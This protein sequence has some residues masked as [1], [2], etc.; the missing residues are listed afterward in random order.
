[1]LPLIAPG[2]RAFTA[3]V[4]RD[5]SAAWG[6]TN[7]GHTQ[8]ISCKPEKI[9]CQL[10]TL[11]VI[12]IGIG[13]GLTASPLPHHRT[14]GSR[15][16][17]FGRLS[18][19]YTAPPPA[20][21]LPACQPRVHPSGRASPD[22]APDAL[23]PLHPGPRLRSTVGRSRRAGGPM[24]AAA[25]CGAVR[26]DSSALRPQQPGH[27]AAL[28]GSA[29]IPSGPRRRIDQARPN[30]GWRALRSRA[31]S[32]R[33]DHTSYPVRVPSPHLRSTRPS[34]PTSR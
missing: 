32:P 23:A 15:L 6:P 26:G 5:A 10:L 13:R 34:D 2:A 25:G 17:R 24:P 1:M 28:P 20:R 30:G 3:R 11:E 29:V 4:S 8:K 22:P 12:A 27:P 19:G 16:R 18:I 31:R 14:Y 9:C 33:A 7:F 21:R